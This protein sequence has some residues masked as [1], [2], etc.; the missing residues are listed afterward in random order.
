VCRVTKDGGYIRLGH[1]G[2]VWLEIL[3]NYYMTAPS[4][5]TPDAK[6]V[7]WPRSLWLHDGSVAVVTVQTEMGMGLSVLRVDRFRSRGGIATV[8]APSR[9]PTPIPLPL[10]SL[11]EPG[12]RRRG[13]GRG[14]QADTT[15]S[16]TFP[17]YFCSSLCTF[18][19]GGGL[20]EM[21][22]AEGEGFHLLHI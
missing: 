21:S 3:F 4:T 22:N 5:T 7:R 14:G 10:S 15:H 16:R 19:R 1:T 6:P 8:N 20:V 9:S 13:K 17:L 11:E 18:A 2:F 12:H